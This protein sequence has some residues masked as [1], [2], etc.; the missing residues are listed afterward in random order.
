MR[1]ARVGRCPEAS[2]RAAW[3]RCPGSGVRESDIA[4]AGGVEGCV[5]PLS[6]RDSPEKTNPTWKP[7]RR[8]CASRGLAMTHAAGMLIAVLV[9]TWTSRWSAAGVSERRTPVTVRLYLTLLVL[10]SRV[11]RRRTAGASVAVGRV[12][13]AF[14]KSDRSEDTPAALGGPRQPPLLPTDAR[15]SSSRLERRTRSRQSDV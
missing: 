6:C 10:G 5:P 13:H 14:S 3:G 4:Y 9:A 2:A 8:E 15:E 12:I 1:P 11:V 7:P